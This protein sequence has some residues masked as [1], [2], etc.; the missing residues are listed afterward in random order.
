MR[1]EHRY[2]TS[3]REVQKSVSIFIKKRLPKGTISAR[4][5]SR[6]TDCTRRRVH[7]ICTQDQEEARSQGPGICADRSIQAT[8]S[9]ITD[10][11][12]AQVSKAHEVGAILPDAV[13]KYPGRHEMQDNAE[14]N[15]GATRA[16]NRHTTIRDSIQTSTIKKKNPLQSA[17]FPCTTEDMFFTI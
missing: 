3:L 2:S 14:L 1:L 11:P 12:S 15:P 16:Q 10:C 17:R 7:R 6:L 5:S 4:K 9:T 13:E 8:G